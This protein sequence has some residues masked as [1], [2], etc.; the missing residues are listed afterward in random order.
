MDV[1]CFNVELCKTDIRLYGNFNLFEDS[2]VLV[3]AIQKNDKLA[4]SLILKFI[5]F[6]RSYT[7]KYPIAIHYN[8]DNE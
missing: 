8:F 2:I 7:A 1:F 4:L 3:A 5:S 6:A